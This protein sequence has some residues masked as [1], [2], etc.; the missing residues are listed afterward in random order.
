MEEN[1]MTISERF[2]LSLAIITLLFT[3]L[4][5]IKLLSIGY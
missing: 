5:V 3:V 1:K 2:V 4:S